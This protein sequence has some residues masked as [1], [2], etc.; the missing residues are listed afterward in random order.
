MRRSFIKPLLYVLFGLGAF[1]FIY[2]LFTNPTSLL[3]QAGYVFLFFILFYLLYR[4]V[5]RPSQTKGQDKD[6]LRAVKQ[7]KRRLKGRGQ[8]KVEVSPYSTM[9]KGT[10][11]PNSKL[12]SKSTTPKKKKSNAH[13]TVIEGK[14]GKKKNRAFF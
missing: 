11:Q 7:S 1:G 4:F 3:R 5:L 13:L 12:S 10:K 9:K 8:S 6:Y 2:T 14:K